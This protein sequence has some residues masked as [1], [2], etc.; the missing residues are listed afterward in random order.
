MINGKNIVVTWDFTEVSEYAALHAI[1]MANHLK[2]NIVLLHIIKKDS[3]KELAEEQL[4]IKANEI[5]N[6][7]K[8][9]TAFKVI[10]G[11]I[12][13]SIGDYTSD[14]ENQ[15]N[16][17]IMGTHGIRGMQKITGS[18]A[19]KVIASSTV[20]FLVVQDKP[21]EKK[22]TDIVFPLDF[23]AENKEKLVWA[24]YLAQYFTL[25]IHI[26]KELNDDDY[27]QKKINN[28]LL[29]AKKYLTKYNIDF[30]IH[31][32]AQKGNFEKQLIDFAEEINADLILVMTTKNI[33]FA[34]Y[35]FGASEQDIIANSAKLPILCVNPRNDLMK[36]NFWS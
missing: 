16:M 12:F 30:E 34:D 7:T 35:V 4:Q 32:A 29:F 23:K 22:L 25:K 15:V 27:Y 13:H 5:Q 6:N 18:W 28:N 26:F 36:A 20:P 3:D 19:L 24:I 14:D 21:S 2:C 1:K 10:K 33:G 31:T 11:D 8:I 9:P 17:V